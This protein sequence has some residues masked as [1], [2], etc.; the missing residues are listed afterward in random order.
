M[1]YAKNTKRGQSRFVRRLLIPGDEG[2][3]DSLKTWGWMDIRKVANDESL[4][5]DRWENVIAWVAMERSLAL[6]RIPET[7]IR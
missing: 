2:G 5:I 4:K 6:E 1:Q 3:A 7:R